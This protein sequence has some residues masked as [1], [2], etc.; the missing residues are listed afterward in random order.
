MPVHI[1]SA[2]LL[3]EKGVLVPLLQR[4]LSAELNEE[5]FDWLYLNG[6]HGAAQAWLCEDEGGSVIG[7][8][9]AFPRKLSVCGR[10]QRAWVLGDFCLD[11]K[12]RTLGPGLTLQRTCLKHT[13]TAA[14]E[15]CYDLPSDSMMAIY[16]RLG[17]SQN[18]RLVRWVKPLSLTR[19]LRSVLRSGRMAN[20]IG[21]PTGFLLRRRGGKVRDRIASLELHEGRCTAEFS[22]LNTQVCSGPG[23]LT[24]RSAE[25]LN[26]RYL[27]HPTGNYQILTA[28]RSNALVAYAV[29][30]H[31]GDRVT[32]ADICSIEEPP[33][34]R[35]LLAG[36]SR[37]AQQCGAE[38]LSLV[39][40]DSHPWKNS[41]RR[42]GFYPRE[43]S[44]LV[45]C[46][47]QESGK[48]SSKQIFSWYLMNGER[49][50]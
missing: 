41:F 23:V 42:A 46:E 11:P 38:A 6:P 50:S 21:I 4:L 36:L 24:D 37:Q 1:R 9:A 7:A 31:E 45:A 14:G 48:F 5:K 32:I 40:A 44:S 19:K 28:R 8:A 22:E 39:A 29:F 18:G 10:L 3:R 35:V 34:V 49:E 30:A 47:L 16:S 2:D 43:F 33:L 26:W 13:C 17:I 25:Y 20:A 12:F 15:F 27:D